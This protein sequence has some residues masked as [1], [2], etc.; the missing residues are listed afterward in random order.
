MKGQGETRKPL[1]YGLMCF[2]GKLGEPTEKS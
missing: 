2:S 1:S